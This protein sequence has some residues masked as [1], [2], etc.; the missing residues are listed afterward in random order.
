M[1]KK[2]L[3]LLISITAVVG[4]FAQASDDAGLWT[5]FNLDKKLND[6]FSLFLTEEFRLRE[7]FT[8]INLFYTDLGVEYRPA[9][10]LKV[11]LSY[12]LI[13]KN[14]IDDNYSFRHRVMLDITLKKKFGKVIL[15]YRNRTQREVRDVESS[16]DGYLPEWYSRN[17][18]TLK[19]DLD[20]PIQPYIGTEWRYQISNPRQQ[21]TDGLWHRA[22]Y[23]A[24]I[25]Y[26]KSDKHTFGLYYLIQREFNVSAPQNLYIVGIEYSLSL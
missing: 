26:K 11:A 12:R 20:K 14:L 18:F 3:I 16:E 2:I 5:T 24:G 22:R 9:K 15:A 17:K 1:N 8:R 21:E 10:I 7:N 25:D 13:E 4:A 23:V 6:K 19:L